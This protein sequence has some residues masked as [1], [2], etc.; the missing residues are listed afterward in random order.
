M[1]KTPHTPAAEVALE[2]AQDFIRAVEAKDLDAVGRTLATDARQLFMHS[3]RTTTPDGVADII[4][5]RSK[6][7]CVADVNGKKEILAYTEALLDKFVPLIWRN[8]EWTVSPSGGSVFFYGKG[9]MIAAHRGKSYRNTY[10]TRFDIAD[11]RIVKMAEYADALL[12]AGLRVRPNGAEIRA[13]L[14]AIRRIISPA[15]SSRSGR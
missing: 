2:V 9:D 8:H 1:S 3:R 6:G 10:V 15:Q 14:R 13:L 11:G 7:L 5:G 12:Y 4:A